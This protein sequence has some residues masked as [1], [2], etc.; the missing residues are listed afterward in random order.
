MSDFHSDADSSRGF[1]VTDVSE[2]QTS[3]SVHGVTTQKTAACWNQFSGN[4][5]WECEL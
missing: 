3:A 5:F 1:I 2:V 4:W